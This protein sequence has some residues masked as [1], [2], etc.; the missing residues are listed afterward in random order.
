MINRLSKY[1][2]QPDKPKKP[3]GPKPDQP[4]SRCPPGPWC[5]SERLRHGH[6]V[7]AR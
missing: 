3:E 1:F 7:L 5:E 6:S 2:E 4:R